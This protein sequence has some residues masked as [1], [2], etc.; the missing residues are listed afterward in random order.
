M[1]E[2]IS[3]F[4]Y[5]TVCYTPSAQ[6]PST[7]DVTLCIL[8]CM[9]F[10]N[11]SVVTLMSIHLYVMCLFFL[12]TFKIISLSLAGSNLDDEVLWFSFLH[13]SCSWTTLNFWIYFS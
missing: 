4:I 7:K 13:V 2:N 5:L 12:A 11:E 8:T 1:F 3:I 9:V 6:P 10:D